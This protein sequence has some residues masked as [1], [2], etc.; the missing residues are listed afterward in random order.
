V[1][2]TL[3][4]VLKRGALVA[5]ANWPVICIQA[6]TGSLF[7]LLVA[8]PLLGGIVLVTLVIG[9]DPGVLVSLGWREL[10]PTIVAALGSRPVVL[11]SFLAAVAVVVVGGSL[12]VFLIKAGTVAV[13]IQGERDAEAIEQPPLC[14]ETIAGASSFSI[15]RFVDSAGRLFPRYARLGLLLMATYLVAGATYVTVVFVSPA[16]ERWLAT[17]LVTVVFVTA[18]TLINLVY[19]LAQIIMAADD[20]GPG[21]A[22]ARVAGF[23]RHE[24]WPILAVFG[25][26]MVMLVFAAGASVLAT[27]LLGLIAFVPVFGLAVLPLQLIAWMLR[28]LVFEYI[29]LTSIGAYGRLY[30][31][32][33]GARAGD[34]A[35]VYGIR[36]PGYDPALDGRH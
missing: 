3:K 21:Q 25:V 28:R 31:A 12:L 32:H 36:P 4:I 22:A 16:G 7:T 23:L 17:A 2:P 9:A 26:V 8:V 20:C 34:E 27:G 33:A 24:P 30:R 35:R 10:V 1:L 18:I 13:L 5:A 19:L 29:A 15:E 11:A 6:V 14:L